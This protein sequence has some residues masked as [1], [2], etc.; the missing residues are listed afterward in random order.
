MYIVSQ[1]ADENAFQGAGCILENIQKCDLEHED[2]WNPLVV[3]LRLY[4]EHE[5]EWNPLVVGL[6][7]CTSRNIKI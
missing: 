5:D 2:K 6:R 3:G 1:S 7:L 4:L